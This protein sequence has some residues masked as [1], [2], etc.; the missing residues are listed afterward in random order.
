MSRDRIALLMLIAHLLDIEL[1]NAKN[2][3]REWN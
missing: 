2:K 1:K 3:C